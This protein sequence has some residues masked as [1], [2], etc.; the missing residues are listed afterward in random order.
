MLGIALPFGGLDGKQAGSGNRFK[1][2]DVITTYRA[3]PAIFKKGN[4]L[5]KSIKKSKKTIKA[6]REI[7][8]I[9]LFDLLR[10]ER[11]L[12]PEKQSDGQEIH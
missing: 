2:G 9:K 10:K 4:M 11:R 6:L 7:L 5:H 12:P 3:S 8:L 1:R